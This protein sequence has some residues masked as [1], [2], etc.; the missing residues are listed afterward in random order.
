VSAA[1]RVVVVALVHRLRPGV[2]YI[3][4]VARLVR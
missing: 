3:N 4:A 1:V 2:V